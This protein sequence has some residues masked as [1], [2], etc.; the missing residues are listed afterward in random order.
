[1]GLPSNLNRNAIAVFDSAKGVMFGNTQNG[2]L[3]GKPSEI[4]NH[5]HWPMR[6]R[7][8]Y[9]LWGSGVPHEVLPEFSIKDIVGRLATVFTRLQIRITQ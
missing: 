3:V 6:Y 5:G 8:V 1:M 9:V 4:G 2:K 7:S